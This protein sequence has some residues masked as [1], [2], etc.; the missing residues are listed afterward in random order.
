MYIGINGIILNMKRYWYYNLYY[1]LIF[2]ADVNTWWPNGYG[3]QPLY[4]LSIELN[5]IN[6]NQSKNISI[7]FRTAE[8]IQEPIDE[9]DANMGIYFFFVKR[10]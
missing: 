2:Q 10:L 4:N 9:K 8:L 3:E 5:T 6:D 7:G 1:I